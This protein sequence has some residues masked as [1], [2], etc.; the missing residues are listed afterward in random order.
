MSYGPLAG[1]DI[2]ND[3]QADLLKNYNFMCK[4]TGCEE[5]WPLFE[6]KD[7]VIILTD[8]LILKDSF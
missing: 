8:L 6:K 7:E 3:R 1:Y 5:D 4:C 2:K